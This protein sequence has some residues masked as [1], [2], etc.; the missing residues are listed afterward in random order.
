MTLLRAAPVAIALLATIA[1][2][3][4]LDAH[5]HPIWW[6][7][8]NYFN[9]VV[10]DRQA[11][12]QGGAVAG[13]KSL[14]FADNVR[15]PAYRMIVAPVAAVALPSLALLRTIAFCVTAAAFVLLWRACRI[16]ASPPSALLAAAI[17]FSI[18]EILSTGAWFGTE[19]ALIFAIALLLD[20]LLRDQPVGVAAAVALGLLSKASF[21]V[22]GGPALL[23][24]MLL[25]REQ[26]RKLMLSAAAGA[27]IAAAWWY[28]DPIDALEFAQ[29]GRVFE[30][31][32]YQEHLSSPVLGTKLARFAAALGPGILLAAALLGIEAIRQREPVSPQ[33]RRA[34]ILAAVM[35]V[36]LI[37]LSLLSPTF[38]P[39]HFAPALLAAGIPIAIALDRARNP[40][41]LGVAFLALLQVT[42]MAIAP[43][44]F[45]P[46]VEQTDWRGLRAA[47]P[48]TAP[49]IVMLGGWPSL[50]PPEIRYGWTRDGLEAST[51][52]LWRAEDR[53]IDWRHVMRDALAADAV[54]VVPPG[55]SK[56]EGLTPYERADNRHNAELMRRLQATGTF[57]EPVAMRIGTSM[58]TDVLVFRRHNS[59]SNPRPFGQ[60]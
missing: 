56:N 48:Q 42:W 41:R 27:L 28:W 31:L 29:L 5:P 14:L 10:D 59:R 44:R 50:S 60:E 38:V 7:E 9:Q 45:L 23:T 17:V 25:S 47:V 8:A 6:D 13:L 52:W 37:V 26:I 21:F 1:A 24:A 54:L 33:A 55:E 34:V 43:Q 53:Q 16:V 49:R 36:P 3:R 19:Y 58:K 32:S 11:F 40:V 35:A 57:A 18:P 22:I 2:V 30:R 15:P 46:R 4:W 12:L 39:R 51:L 20:S